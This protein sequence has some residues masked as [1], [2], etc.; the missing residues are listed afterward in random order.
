MEKTNQPKACHSGTLIRCKKSS[1]GSSNNFHIFISS[2]ISFLS[3]DWIYN[4]KTQW[5]ASNWLVSPVGRVLQRYRRESRSRLNFFHAGLW[6]IFPQLQKFRVQL[7]WP[8]LS[9]VTTFVFS[10]LFNQEIQRGVSSWR[11]R[12]HR[13]PGTWKFPALKGFHQSSNQQFW[14]RQ[15]PDKRCNSALLGPLFN[16]SPVKYILY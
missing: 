14:S 15:R 11:I 3:Q 4:E 16:Y 7:K 9:L 8:S 2:C 10:S 1:S 13:I 12:K 6:L 5:P